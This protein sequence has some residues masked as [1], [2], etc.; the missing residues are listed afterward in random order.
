VKFF[1]S[2]GEAS[3]EYHGAALARAL[4]KLDP[5]AEIRGI[6]GTRMGAAGVSLTADIR[7]LSVMGMVEL[8]PRL[9][10]I[11]RLKK[12]VEGEI[13]AWKPDAVILIDFPDFNLRLADRLHAAGLHTVYF[14]PPKLW[15]W[16]TWRVRKLKRVIDQVLV[17]FPFETDFYAKHGVRAA[18]VGNPLLDD[19]EGT[20]RPDP[21]GPPVI[22]L[23]PGS[24]RG[25]V[26]KLLPA[27]VDAVLELRKS[28]PQARFVLP[29]A[30]SVDH[31]WLRV[32]EEAGV[33]LHARPL[34]E[35]LLECDFAW[36]ASGTATLEAALL[37][38]PMVVVYKL[39]PV[40]LAIARR[41]VK[42]SH[43]SLPNILA[44][45]ELVPELLQNEVN[46]Q[47]LAQEARR[48]VDDS[49]ARRKMHADLRGLRESLGE[50]G[51]P[52]RAA[53]EI[54]GALKPT[55]EM[56]NKKNG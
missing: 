40:S 56:A 34:S 50:R 54:L 42:L 37:E 28:H 23:V 39:H 14:I 46:G 31:E 17:I 47:R 6:G 52:D 15:A 16:R 35:V 26:G 13:K 7:T 4:Q 32:A 25:E 48:I 10:D 24:R 30:S 1:I 20:A 45:R 18:Y 9:R 19:C 5:Q 12:R 55:M 2:T 11:L 29:V 53:R 8:L 22:G 27:M 51:A 36:V 3:G 21:V 38:V 44:D 43:F 41:F 33:E 49:A